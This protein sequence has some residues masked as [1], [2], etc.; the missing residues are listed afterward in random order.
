MRSPRTRFRP[1]TSA[2]RSL[3]AHLPVLRQERF[4]RAGLFLIPEETDPPPEIQATLRHLRDT[5][6]PPTFADAVIDPMLN[7]LVA[8]VAIPRPA[9]PVRMRK[10]RHTL[11]E[12]ALSEGSDALSAR[13]QS[14]LLSD[15]IALSLL[16]FR[17][18]TQPLAH[19]QWQSLRAASP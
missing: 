1:R 4:R 16:H 10:Q 14:E 3:P 7:A 18:W 12:L 9:L 13:E 5:P 2:A 8:A 11:V 15:P 19:P 6:A 17:A